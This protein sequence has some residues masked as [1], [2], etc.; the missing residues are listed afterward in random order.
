MFSLIVCAIFSASPEG[1]EKLPLPELYRALAPQP[2]PAWRSASA[3]LGRRL[4]KEKRLSA[5]GT[6]SCES[7]HD[8]TRAFTD[9]K[10]RGVGVR[11]QVGGRN[12]PTLINRT[13]GKTHFWDGRA[14]T[15]EE[16]ALGPLE[17]PIEMA[18]PRAEAVDFLNRT[19]EY[20]DEFKRV[21]GGPATPERLAQAF[22]DYE[23]TIYSVDSPFDRYLK[24]EES[25]L[26]P[27]AR[28]GLSLFG[29][30]ARCS[31]CHSGANF[32]DERFHNL[33]VDRDPGR[34]AVTKDPKD[35]G[36]FKTP[37]LREVALTGPYMHDGS[38]STLREVID[39]YDQGGNPNPG[40][41][42]KMVPLKLSESEK[43]DLEAFLRALSGRIVEGVVAQ[44]PGPSGTISGVVS[45]LEGA[46]EQTVVYLEVVPEPDGAGFQRPEPAAISQKNARFTPS[47]LPVL[48]GSL[49][50]FTNDDWAEHNAYSESAIRPFD[51]GVYAKDKRKMVSF[52]KAGRVEV[53]CTIHSDMSAVIL[54]LQNPYFT[55]PEPQG[56][57]T[58]Q[59]VPVGKY[60]LVLF[61]KGKAD[62]AVEVVVK[63]NAT[64]QVR[65]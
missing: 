36:A 13:L 52:D 25:A 3:A 10:P 4:Y 1:V 60:R 19:P 14:R 61:Q 58:L 40:L 43:A 49:V 51:L 2:L 45:G 5:D 44:A 56:A 41:D 7:C 32:S 47:V 48:K 63:K 59:R 22:A 31:D 65:L 50:D 37:T 34:S 8:L 27:A 38:M 15:L 53:G 62:R 55:R 20:R 54:V 9:G 35:L 46:V 23:R 57:F 12:T 24:G 29:R 33:G 28:R 30:K 39:F 11:G 17:N 16:Q 18:R 26:S 42:P 6:V 21:F 64:A